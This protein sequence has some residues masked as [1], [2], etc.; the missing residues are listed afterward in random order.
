MCR[1]ASIYDTGTQISPGDLLLT[2]STCDLR[3]DKEKGRIVIQAKLTPV[4]AR[5]EK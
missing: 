1:E 5:T 4:A 2:L 3:Y